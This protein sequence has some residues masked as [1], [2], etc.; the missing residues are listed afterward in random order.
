MAL[1]D[2][3][4]ASP[5][6]Q[7]FPDDSA[8]IILKNIPQL[9]SKK[10]LDEYLVCKDFKSSN[11]FILHVP[12]VLTYLFLTACREFCSTHHFKNLSPD[13]QLFLEHFFKNYKPYAYTQKKSDYTNHQLVT[14]ECY[15]AFTVKDRVILDRVCH[16]F[17]ITIDIHICM[18]HF[19][20]FALQ[21]GYELQKVFSN[22]NLLRASQIFPHKLESISLANNQNKPA[23]YCFW[24]TNLEDNEQ[25]KYW[26]RL[27]C[28]FFYPSGHCEFRNETTLQMSVEQRRSIFETYKNFFDQL[29][30][31]CDTD[32]IKFDDFIFKTVTFDIE[33]GSQKYTQ[34]LPTPTTGYVQ[35]V[36][37]RY[38]NLKKSMLRESIYDII[39]VFCPSGYD[40][41]DVLEKIKELYVSTD[42]SYFLKKMRIFIYRDEA[43]MIYDILLRLNFQV[44]FFVG[45]N[46]V[47][48]DYI[49]LI[50]RYNF[51]KNPRCVF[52][53][54]ST[55]IIFCNNFFNQQ[56]RSKSNAFMPRF[57]TICSKCNTKVFLN[58]G[59]PIFTEGNAI[60][61][62]S[63]PKCPRSFEVFAD[64]ISYS[65]ENHA[66]NFRF[67]KKRSGA[68]DS[69]PCAYSQDLIK[70]FT[71]APNLKL[72]TVVKYY[73]AEEVS[74]DIEKN[75][76]VV[77]KKFQTASV[78]YDYVET[79]IPGIQL[80]I[81]EKNT[82]AKMMNDLYSCNLDKIFFQISEELLSFE[83][84]EDL[85]KSEELLQNAPKVKIVLKVINIIKLGEKVDTQTKTVYMSFG[86]TNT[87]DIQEQI[88]WKSLK[89]VTETVMYC[90][91]DVVITAK[92]NHVYLT[93]LPVYNSTFLEQYPLR[94]LS[95]M[96]GTQVIKLIAKKYLQENLALTRLQTPLSLMFWNAAL[97]C[98]GVKRTDL[99]PE[100]KADISKFNSSHE[101][102]FRLNGI[103]TAEELMTFERD[104]K[105]LT[106]YAIN[107]WQLDGYGTNSFH[108]ESFVINLFK[109][110]TTHT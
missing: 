83:T 49:F 3:V 11:N 65:K 46:S 72:D 67:N 52:N 31:P 85:L 44:D 80:S 40:A 88:E 8:F 42:K 86:K 74:L 38:C 91:F 103:R 77:Y 78:L 107:S 76:I 51:L 32:T 57:F 9:Y 109:N 95:Y 12:F 71:D 45:Y 30:K 22:S 54:F 33:A 37:F 81:F 50:I 99:P 64:Q 35:T 47:G 13:E 39:F 6:K 61:W 104:G 48:F 4:A 68:D 101:A 73:L 96:S 41:K 108:N 21:N 20:D 106:E 97:E 110:L 24:G 25:D 60:G 16:I 26:T 94:L 19:E 62:V 53:N 69:L 59:R 7:I 14:F 43:S 56:I 55:S 70:I 79:L 17:Q 23:D 102:V 1:C 66:G 98:E 89:H 105:K 100:K 90:W 92:L 93:L 10:Y 15:L 18:S 58:N 87:L 63:C 2:T 29:F 82:L 27:R 84:R 34:Q 5:L 28:L 75:E 36:V